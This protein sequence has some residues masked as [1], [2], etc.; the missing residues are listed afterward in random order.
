MNR[1][2][3]LFAG[4]LAW[5][6]L[7]CT[8]AELTADGEQV[9]IGK[10]DPAD[11]CTEIGAVYGSAS[12]YSSSEGKLASAEIGLRNKAAVLGANYVAMDAIDMRTNT[13]M[14]RAFRCE[15]LP[16][17]MAPTDSAG[18]APGPPPSTDPEVRLRKLKELLDKGLIT[19]EDYDK[20]RAEILQS[21]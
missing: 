2:T 5:T 7:G 20:R 18:I 16:S 19:Q 21:L 8:P 15:Q 6:A 10:N 1:T 17:N 14:G 13:I 12:G 3:W 9:R 11:G 4:L